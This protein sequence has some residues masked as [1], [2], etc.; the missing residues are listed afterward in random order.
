LGGKERFA[1]LVEET[2]FRGECESVVRPHRLLTQEAA[3]SVFDSQLTRVDGSTDQRPVDLFELAT[4]R[5]LG[6]LEDDHG[7]VG[8]VIS[9][10]D[11]PLGR[12]TCRGHFTVMICH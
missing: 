10:N 1:Q 7:L 3:H 9:D 2:R 4:V 5:A 11:T 6:I 8:I 12:V